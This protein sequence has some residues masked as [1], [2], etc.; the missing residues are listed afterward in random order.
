[1]GASSW[2]WG[3]RNGMRNCQRV[4]WKGDDDWIVKKIKDND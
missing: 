3:R 4:D 2:R 1:V